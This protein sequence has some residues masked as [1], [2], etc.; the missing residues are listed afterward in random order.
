MSFLRNSG[1]K[2]RRA[3]ALLLVLVFALSLPPAAAFAAGELTEGEELLKNGDFSDPL[4]FQLYK[5]SG[6]AAA[7]SIVDGQLQ[8]DVSA[9]G[10]VAHAIQ[11]YYDGFGLVQGVEYELS[12][13]V[14]S[15]LPRELYVRVQLNG[16][17]YHAYFE[18]LIS[19]TEET[20]HFCT[21]FVM[22]EASDPAPRLCVN[23]GYVDS[24][25]DAGRAP[26]DVPPHQVYFDNF[27]LTVKDAGGAVGGED[28]AETAGIRVNQLGYL[29]DAAKTAVFADVQAEGDGFTVLNTATGETAFTG[30]LSAPE[31][32]PWAGETDRIADFSAL[33]E[34]GSYQVL[35]SD[36]TA[37]PEFRIGEDVYD[38]LLRSVLRMLYLQRCGTALDAEIA[39]PFAHPDCHEAPAVIYGTEETLDV[40]GG[41]HDA[42]DYGRYV[43]SG[44]KA[45][46]DLLLSVERDG[47]LLDDVGIPESGDGLD[48]RLQEARWELDW[49]LKMQTAD[50]GVYHKVTCR[51]FPGIIP[52][53]EEQEE[54]VVCPVSN[55]AT[56][57]F[58]GVMALAAR[59]FAE[60]GAAELQAAASEYLA[61]AERAWAY[62]AEHEN[63]PG[64]QNPEDVL[65]GEYPDGKAADERFWAAA[66]LART[67]GEARY[68]EAALSLLREGGVTAEL[69][70]VE[71]GGYGLYA[72]LSD[73]ALAEG[74]ELHTLAKGLL[75]GETADLLALMAANPYGIS[76]SDRYEWGSNMGVANA[77]VLLLMAGDVLGG[78][79]FAPAALRQLDYLLGE[80]ATGYCFVSGMG[81]RSP[82]HPHHRPSQLLGEAMP[83][84]LAG[85]P[86][87]D[88]EDPFAANVLRSAAPARCY[89]DSD[90]S[91]STNEVTVYW[92]SPLIALLSAAA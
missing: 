85:G 9:I 54:L 23:M 66:E 49:L 53:Q 65:T 82:E 1:K 88:L 17:D 26:E 38:E 7:I 30:S 57:D 35:A 40:S 6:G 84:M 29:P 3:A 34:P 60:S 56:G 64:F 43:V 74:D 81:S 11:P 2:L 14:R 55:T 75:E 46:A 39:G 8:V 48:D 77:G 71:M 59:L 78:E 52:P 72:L 87:S 70:W 5:E 33:T 41:W 50:G 51:T 45:A 62:L 12:Y 31:D 32:N 61:A 36:G 4:L 83:G 47:R 15:T 28:A 25:Q 10:R 22:E 24:M 37:S 58:A 80:N 42:G 89:A 44:A 69:G 86:N 63:E 13:D 19:V 76:R 67:T 16:G 68:R 92:N 27:S 18:Q 20:Q 73:P 90:Q 21:D 79:D 91:F